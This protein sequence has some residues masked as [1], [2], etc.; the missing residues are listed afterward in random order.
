M[1]CNGLYLIIGALVV[2][3]AGFAIYTYQQESKPS[4]IEMKIGEG[5]I[6]IQEN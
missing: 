2:V 1:N 6:S 3:V 5:G 4:G